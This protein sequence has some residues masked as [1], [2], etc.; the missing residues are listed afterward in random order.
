MIAY[1]WRDG[2]LERVAWGLDRVLVPAPEP[3]VLVPF[4]PVSKRQ[5]RQWAHRGTTGRRGARRVS[6]VVVLS[7]IRPCATP[8][9]WARH[10]ISDGQREVWL[11]L[12]DGVAVTPEMCAALGLTLPTNIA[13]ARA[14]EARLASVPSGRFKPRLTRD[15]IDDPDYV[16]PSYWSAV[17]AYVR[18]LP[19]F[20]PEAEGEGP[21]LPDLSA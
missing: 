4:G 13:G 3:R 7:R 20:P 15:Q 10:L 14:V 8:E 12:P 18:A 19:P 2:A 5:R 17:A 6:P 1:R 16:D 9:V 21:E 11:Y